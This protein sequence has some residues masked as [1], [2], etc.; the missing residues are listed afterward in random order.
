MPVDS[1]E[2]LVI[3]DA[4]GAPRLL[5]SYRPAHNQAHLLCRW[6]NEPAHAFGLRVAKGLSKIRRG[7]EVGTLTLVL[8]GDLT[9]GGVMPE[10]SRDLASAIA[11]SGSVNLVG[12]GAPQVE[13]VRWMESLRT[14]V[15]PAVVVEARFSAS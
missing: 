10:L 1:T 6:P 15:G 13:L 4:Q 11:P 12:M 7:A 5:E 2:V 8:G 9:L 3:D 14:T